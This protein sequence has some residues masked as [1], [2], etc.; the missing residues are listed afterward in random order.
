MLFARLLRRFVTVGTL[1]IVDAGGLV[2][3][4]RGHD[5][6]PDVTMRLHNRRVQ[7]RL[8]WRPALAV[9]E[10]YMDG[11]LTVDGGDVYPLLDLINRN[12]FRA[13]YNPLSRLHH[14]LTWPFRL[15]S[16]SNSVKRAR[17]NAAY[18]YDLD[19]EFY[20]LFLDKHMQYTCAYFVRRDIPL[21]HAQEEKMLHLAAKLL[22]K[23]GVTVLEIGCG[24]GNLAAFLAGLENL[25]VQ[26]LTLSQEQLREAERLAREKGV[27]SRVQFYLRDYRHERGQYDRVVSV[28]MLE[29]VGA[30]HYGTYFKKIH[31]LLIEDGVAVIHFIGR[32]EP[33]TETAPWLN[34]YIFPGGYAPA[35]SE[36]LQALEKQRLFLTDVEVWRDHY[37]P[38]LAGW[39]QRL[40]AN[41]EQIRARFGEPF[42]R[43][44]D[45]YLAGSEAAFRQ[46]TFVVFQLQLARRRETVPPTRDYIERWK[47]AQRLVRTNPVTHA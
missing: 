31:D 39:R 35:L 33:P 37:A 15:L 47:D 17:R 11:S 5:P 18:T 21:E 38:T 30:R 29:H 42:C 45:F 2:H 28:G 1:R 27:D 22:L 3:T 34:K 25:I 12:I 9:G 14:I 6:G 41:W 20:R 13:G 8:L 32:M 16:G 24:W 40:H 19:T 43:M 44:F 10:A 36:V 4:I 26:G 23:P 7:R 46:D